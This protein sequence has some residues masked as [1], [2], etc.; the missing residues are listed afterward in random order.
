MCVLTGRPK[1]YAFIEYADP[2]TALSAIRNLDG[3][4]FNGRNLRVSYSNNSALKDVAREMGQVVHDSYQS[5]NC[6]THPLLPQLIFNFVVFNCLRI[7]GAY[8]MHP[9]PLLMWWMP[10][11]WMKHMT[12]S[13]L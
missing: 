12:S 13:L 9:R 1:G 6:F 7:Q 10:C 4:D 2:N 8:H 3:V 5:G 11:S